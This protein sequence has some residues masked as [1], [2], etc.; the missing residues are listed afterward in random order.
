[1]AVI[2]YHA[3]KRD[4]NG[5]IVDEQWIPIYAD[6]INNRARRD[7]NLSDLHD[8]SA[9]R[10]N[11]GLVGDVTEIPNSHNHDQHYNVWRQED[12]RN[13]DAAHANLDSKFTK[14]I[15]DNYVE[16]NSKLD[17]FKTSFTSLNAA[18]NL[19]LTAEV[20]DRS[21][22]DIRINA[23]IDTT[24]KNLAAEQQARIN[25]DANLQSQVDVNKANIKINKDNIAD[26]NTRLNKEI[27]DRANG[28]DALSKKID[29]VNSSLTAKLNTEAT[30]RANSDNAL[31]ARITTNANNLATE[32]S[33]RKSA[34]DNQVARLNGHDK[35]LGSHA[36]TL[37][38][39]GT[40]IAALET[41]GVNHDNRI[42][43]LESKSTNNANRITTETSARQSADNNL[44]NRITAH[45]RRF[46]IQGN[47]PGGNAPQGAIW[48]NT[49]S[50]MIY[51]RSG[52]SW[53]PFIGSWL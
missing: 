20:N 5:K 28:D 19:R 8:P 44:S 47:D 40:R 6:A 39:H 46:W 34:D 45:E 52:N 33:T 32:A 13:N 11:L 2:K 4:A 12:K 18:T 7:Y 1:M 42:A 30:T 10:K 25:A 15:S 53:V 26:L 36:N 29:S 14:A 9:A 37:S 21:N 27:Q 3:I 22:E 50:R 24:N 41:K 38:N 16:M 43:A 48:F 49:S 51:Y 23:R 31:S 35:T 17:A